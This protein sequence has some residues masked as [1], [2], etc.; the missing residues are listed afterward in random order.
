LDKCLYIYKH[1]HTYLYIYVCVCVCVYYCDSL[2]H[3]AKS[4]NMPHFGQPVFK[5]EKLFLEVILFLPYS[6]PFLNAD[7][8]Y[9]QLIGWLWFAIAVMSCE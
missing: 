4:D 2:P 9:R 5:V 6:T 8:V 3:I 1:T 7:F